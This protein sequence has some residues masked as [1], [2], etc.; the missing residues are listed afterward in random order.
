MKSKEQTYTVEA[1]AKSK[2]FSGY[3]PDFVK[4]ILGDGEYTVE[5][6]EKKIQKYYAK[7][8]K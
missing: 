7:E 6:A 4:A 8:G 2:R 5:E 1:L 3:Q